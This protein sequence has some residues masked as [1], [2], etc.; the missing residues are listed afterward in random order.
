MNLFSRGDLRIDSTTTDPDDRTRASSPPV[1]SAGSTSESRRRSDDLSARRSRRV[2]AGRD[3]ARDLI[4]KYS[5]ARRRRDSSAKP[6]RPRRTYAAMR[7][8]VI[9]LLVIGASGPRRGTGRD[10]GSGSA[11]AHGA[12]LRDLSRHRCDRE[13]L[14]E[15]KASCASSSTGAA[16]ALDSDYRRAWSSA[17]TAAT[18]RRSAQ[19][20]HRGV[21]QS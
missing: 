13:A 16:A 15:D 9:L 6:P 3:R 14:A 19:A 10:A 11:G 21:L 8:L 12:G 7:A 5:S 4:S 1:C 17:V 2:R 20:L 18:R